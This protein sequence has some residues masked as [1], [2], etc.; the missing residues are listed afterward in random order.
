MEME[1]IN[2]DTILVR[3]ENEDLQERGTSVSELLANPTEIEEFFHSILVEMDVIDQ[4]EDSEGMSFQVMPNPEG[5]ELYV[6][7]YVEKKDI[8]ADSERFVRNL[9][10][11][12]QHSLGHR[13]GKPKKEKKVEAPVEKEK[14]LEPLDCTVFF[15]S[16]EDFVQLAKMYPYNVQ[17]SS[18]YRY[19]NYYFLHVYQDVFGGEDFTA[20]VALLRE[21]GEFS[22]VS[23]EVVQEYGEVMIKE[24]AIETAK[25]YFK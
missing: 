25:K 14:I 22:R 21:F 10:D 9:V 7:K 2:D 8:E 11:T 24:K 19:S 15:D 23:W 17:K 4:F 16:F 5:I 20:D 3:I 12:I 1:R 18:L 6:T 13:M